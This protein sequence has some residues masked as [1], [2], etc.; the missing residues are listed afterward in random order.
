MTLVA[1]V[2]DIVRSVLGLEP[3]QV[4]GPAA[5]HPAPGHPPRLV[6]FTGPLGDT[7]ETP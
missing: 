2:P 5:G 7:E 1:I 4:E 3:L 6:V